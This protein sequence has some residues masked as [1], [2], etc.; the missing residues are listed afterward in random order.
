[1]NLVIKEVSE[2]I[3]DLATKLQAGMYKIEGGMSNGAIVNEFANGRIELIDFIVS[4]GLNRHLT[5]DKFDIFDR[6]CNC[7]YTRT[8]ETD[9]RGRGKD[10][11][12]VWISCFFAFLQNV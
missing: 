11:N 10:I 6:R 8:R 7:R 5:F 4:D 12:H 9:F 1:M 2:E 3:L